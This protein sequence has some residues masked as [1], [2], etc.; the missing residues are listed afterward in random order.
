ML[1]A[2]VCPLSSS[3]KHGYLNSVCPVD[4]LSYS[5]N[6][7]IHMTAQRLEHETR[8]ICS[9]LEEDEHMILKQDLKFQPEPDWVLAHEA[10][11]CLKSA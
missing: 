9:I 5:A 8:E 1:K 7:V 10:R 3:V 2:G 4:R 11:Q 6:D